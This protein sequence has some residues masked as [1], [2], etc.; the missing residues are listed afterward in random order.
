MVDTCSSFQRDLCY[1]RGWEHS[2]LI[3]SPF[4]NR[5]PTIRETRGPGQVTI[6]S[7]V[8]P[9]YALGVSSPSIDRVLPKPLNRKLFFSQKDTL[10][11]SE[12]LRG[13]AWTSPTK[14]GIVSGHDLGWALESW[15]TGLEPVE[16]DRMKN[17]SDTPKEGHDSFYL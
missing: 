14:R 11:T 4:W 8:K 16:E 15:C 10:W 3:R 7:R 13:G 2:I 1:D 5:A 9:E 17:G 6:L 12:I